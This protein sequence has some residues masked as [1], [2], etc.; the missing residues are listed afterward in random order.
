MSSDSSKQDGYLVQINKWKQEIQSHKNQMNL[1]QG[2]QKHH[3]L[4]KN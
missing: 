4:Y 3:Q 2:I 1:G